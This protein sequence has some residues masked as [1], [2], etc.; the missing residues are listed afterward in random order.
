MELTLQA[1]PI[2]DLRNS[3]ELVGEVSAVGADSAGK[4]YFVCRQG[5]EAA[6]LE[7]EHASFAKARFDKP[8]T[9][10]VAR[11]DQDGLRCFTV[12]D[13]LVVS[14]VQ[15]L[16]DDQVVLVGARCRWRTN[17]ADKNAAVYDWQGQCRARFPL[18]DGLQDVRTTSGQVIWASYFDEGVFGNYGWGRPYP[19]PIGESGLCSFDHLGQPSFAYDHEAAGTDSI[20]D[21][22]ALNVRSDDD[23]WVYFYTEFPIV[24]VSGSRYR[25]WRCGVGGARAVAV[26]EP[27]VLLFGDY[28][29]R[30]L[31]RVLMLGSDGS[32]RP[33]REVTVELPEGADAG[34]TTAVGI[35]SKLYLFD[36]LRAFV[37]DDWW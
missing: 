8:A 27:H 7:R 34:V 25:Q 28:K 33:I 36:G 14:F 10:T 19:A 1:A 35:G 31:A 2:A 3:P 16:G 22:Y 21:A 26:N 13:E 9:Y 20:C 17:T 18:G 4:L 32:A 11:W 37:V 24:H 29:R 12:K 15:P 30:N 23:V 5:T 6:R